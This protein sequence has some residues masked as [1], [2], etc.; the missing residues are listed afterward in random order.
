MQSKSSSAKQRSSGLLAPILRL[1]DDRSVGFGAEK[2]AEAFTLIELLVVIAIIAL[3]LAI[4]LPSLQRAREQ[5]L[6]VV[7]ANNLK[8]VGLGLRM[9]GDENDGRL[10]L[11]AAGWWLWDI[12]YSTT[13]Y[14]MA[15]TGSERDIFYCPCDHTKNGDMAICWQFSQNPLCEEISEHVEEPTANRDAYYRVTGY[16]WMMDTEPPRTF[17]PQG[18]PEKDWVRT[19][20]EKRPVTKDLVVDATLSDRS[21]GSFT[22]VPGGLW[23]RCDLY[24]RTNHV[25]RG[26]PEGGNVLFLDGHVQWRPFSEMQLRLD[27]ANRPPHYW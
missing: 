14:I 1:Y 27:L 18:T 3:L 26:E 17:H 16:F 11:N 6:K 13:D 4:L 9:Y 25:R 10:P 19:F 20:D 21:T 12:A 22:E 5:S 2:R 23:E 15:K 24:D 8:Q 7:C